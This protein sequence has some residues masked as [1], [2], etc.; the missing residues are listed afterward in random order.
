[1][2]N[3]RGGR[4]AG[5]SGGFT[6]VEM[7]V[8]IVVTGILATG[9]INLLLEQNRFYNKNDEIIFAEQTL[10]GAADLLSR[11]LRMASQRD[12][13]YAGPDSMQVASDVARGVVCRVSGTTITYYVFETP[14]ANLVDPRGT[15]FLNPTA[16]QFDYDYDWDGWGSEASTS[17]IDDCE[18]NGAPEVGTGGVT[19]SDYRTV[20]T[21]G[22]D[23]LTN[24][25][26]ARGATVR[27]FERLAY[28]FEGSNF[29]DGIALWRNRQ[30]L[31]AP[32]AEGAEFVYVTENNGEQQT[33]GAKPWKD[34][35]VIEHVRVNAT[36]TGGGDSRYDVSRDL[37]FQLALRN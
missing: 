24:G 7:L 9:V 32:F 6:L 8:A 22:A 4:P 18:D 21:S 28:H 34:N 20:D 3:A 19:A 12:V 33:L 30:E 15:A 11:E 17:D 16:D 14:A 35:K 1:M 37:S 23:D 36:A 26:P 10:R 27:I 25:T 5:G 13:L 2:S 31:V 29:S